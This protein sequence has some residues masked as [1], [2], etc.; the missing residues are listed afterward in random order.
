MSVQNTGN[1]H[2]NNDSIRDEHRTFAPDF[3]SDTQ[4]ARQATLAGALH[5]NPP[6]NVPPTTP[7]RYGM[8]HIQDTG[9]TSGFGA[10]VNAAHY[11]QP[12]ERPYGGYF[13]DIADD[14]A[15]AM[16]ERTI[17]EAAIEQITIAHQE[18]TIYVARGHLVD[19][20]SIF[21]DTD[22]LHFEMLSS[23][24]GVDYGPEVPRRLHVVYELLSMKY[25]HRV[26]LEVSVDVDDPIVP[27]AV[28]VYPTANWHE[29]EVYDMFGVEFS[30]HPG[31][32]RILMPDDWDGHPQRKDYP[33][34]GIPVE[35]KGHEIP[36]PDQRRAYT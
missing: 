11:P 17:P 16:T 27:S 31:L 24:S 7:E 29:R 13:D 10:V 32:T 25:R 14:L 33:L 4:H 34:G 18:M 21:R 28:A 35:Y 15:A 19:I 30:G 36:A 9:D 2:T 12:A 5:A 3:E 22:T 23:V 20:L 26:R 8:F 6:A 1:D